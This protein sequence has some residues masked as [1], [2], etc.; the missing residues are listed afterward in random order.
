VAEV[1]NTFKGA[2][3]KSTSAA[4]MASMLV[5]EIMPRNSGVISR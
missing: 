1:A 4:S 5:P 3:L 2:A